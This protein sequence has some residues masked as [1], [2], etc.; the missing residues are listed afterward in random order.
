MKVPPGTTLI[1]LFRGGIRS[2]H[3]AQ[4]VIPILVASGLLITGIA[5]AYAEAL[6]WKLTYH[7]VKAE[8][9]E[10]GDVPGHT[11]GHTRASGIAFF[12]N[13][14]VATVS[15]SFTLDYVNGAGQHDGYLVYAFED[16]STFVM[17]IQGSTTPDPG[18]KTSSFKGKFSFTQGSGRFSGITGSGGYAGRRLAPTPAA[19]AELFADFSGTYSR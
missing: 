15:L 9:S 3:M 1:R 14:E 12:D 4:L 17:K 10:V 13:G 7:L 6:K 16:G 18:S 2:I 8:I 11:L 5:P 19:G